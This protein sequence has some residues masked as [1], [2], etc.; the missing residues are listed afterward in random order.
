SLAALRGR[1]VLL[2][3]W[4]SGCVNCQHVAA[5]LRP[6]ERRF[7]RAGSGDLVVIGV[8]SPK[9]AYERTDGA[10]RTAIRRLGVDH[11]VLSDPSLTSWRQ[12]AVKAWP[13]LTLVDPD[14]YVVVQVAGEGHVAGLTALLEQLRAER[15]TGD[16]APPP[17]AAGELGTEARG[18]RWWTGCRCRTVWRSPGTDCS[19]PRATAWSC[20]SRTA[21]ATWSPRRSSAAPPA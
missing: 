6:L 14:G 16:V 1:W 5:E 13:T 3:F 9:F 21:A 20:G 17:P 10:V 7:G 19:S 15:P 11:P 18:A 8:H 2:D 12:Y 4:T